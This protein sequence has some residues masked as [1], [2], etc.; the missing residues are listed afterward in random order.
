MGRPPGHL[1]IGPLCCPLPVYAC[2]TFGFCSLG[3]LPA[4]RG[5]R[6]SQPRID[7]GFVRRSR[8]HSWFSQAQAG[9]RPLPDARRPELRRGSSMV[10]RQA[11]VA[12]LRSDDHLLRQRIH[13]CGTSPESHVLQVLRVLLQTLS[14]GITQRTVGP[15]RP[16][17][18]QSR[19]SRHTHASWLT[20]TRFRS[21][22]RGDFPP[23]G[24]ADP[25]RQYRIRIPFL[26]PR[27]PYTTAPLHPLH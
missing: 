7:G 3:T 14:Q 8:A 2:S 12:R 26:H 16:N 17:G 19:T 24:S 23:T 20:S 10:W 9:S 6:A 1:D 18:Q 11:S 15:R 21:P 25:A 27:I 13:D 5:E 4:R 22:C